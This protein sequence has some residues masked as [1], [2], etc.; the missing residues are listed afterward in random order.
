[1]K[2]HK[3]PPT[4]HLIDELKP[5]ILSKRDAEK[6]T[7]LTFSAYQLIKIEQNKFTVKN[8]DSEDYVEINPVIAQFKVERSMGYLDSLA[9]T[10]EVSL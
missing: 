10:L 5:S 9:E 7:R 2:S 4:T 3:E 1:M 8:K 6:T